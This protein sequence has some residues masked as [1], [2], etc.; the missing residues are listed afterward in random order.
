[1]GHIFNNFVILHVSSFWLPQHF[2]LNGPPCKIMNSQSA[3][4]AAACVTLTNCISQYFTALASSSFCK[5]LTI[6]LTYAVQDASF[7]T[8]FMALYHLILYSSFGGFV[9]YC[10]DLPMSAVFPF[11]FSCRIN[12]ALVPS[13]PTWESSQFSSGFVCW[14]QAWGMLVCPWSI[15]RRLT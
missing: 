3:I 4:P 14:M 11:H 6:Y 10:C 9:G 2:T 1:M 7:F 15:E 13:V 8:V 12:L 5:T